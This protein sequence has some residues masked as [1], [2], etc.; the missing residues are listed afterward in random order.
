TSGPTTHA[1]AR[2]LGAPRGAP[3]SPS[4]GAGSPT[5]PPALAGPRPPLT[6]PAPPLRAPTRPSQPGQ[7]RA[8]RTAGGVDDLRCGDLAPGGGVG[9]ADGGAPL[10]TVITR[11]PRCSASC[12]TARSP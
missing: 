4:C 3:C 5:L 6:L 9:T 7:R 12:R 8:A 11:R 10:A 1:S 2:R